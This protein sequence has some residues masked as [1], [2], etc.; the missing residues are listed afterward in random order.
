MMTSKAE[1]KQSRL[2]IRTAKLVFEGEDG[3]IWV[4]V[5]LNVKL[6]RLLELQQLFKPDDSEEQADSTEQLFG[7]RRFGQDILLEWNIVDEDMRPVVADGEGMMELD[8]VFAQQLIT[9]WVQAV[10]QPAAPLG[11][12]SPNGSTSGEAWTPTAESSLDL[13]SLSGLS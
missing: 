9:Q 11:E 7:L 4:R 5:R 3:D 10:S 1:I 13:G 8:L 2:P 12:T 6:R